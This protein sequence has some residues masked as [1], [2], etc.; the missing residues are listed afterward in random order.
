MSY[1]DGSGLYLAAFA[2]KEPGF[3]FNPQKIIEYLGQAIEYFSGGKIVFINIWGQFNDL[4]EYF[5][6]VDGREFY[7]SQQS[8]Y[9]DDM[10]DSIFDV[11]DFD[12][13]K[14]RSANRR[15]RALTRKD[16]QTNVSKCA[17]FNHEH[18]YIIERWMKAHEIS[19]VHKEF[20]YA[21]RSYIKR[22]TFTYARP[23]QG[24]LVGLSVMAVV[25]NERMVI[26]NSFPM[27]GDGL[28]AGDALFA[29][30]I[31]FA[32][33]KSVRWI[34]RGYSATDS[35]LKTKESWGSMARSRPYREAFY[36]INSEVTEMIKEDRFLWR[37]RLS[38]G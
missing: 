24:V 28:R 4:P 6:S 38:T 3:I 34:H 17:L 30:A 8:D 22:R 13:R 37:L 12:S 9:Y 2:L 27:R 1:C 33:K 21:L 31:S 23:D 18:L 36:V 32:R 11:S 15:I 5:T 19:I 29:E 20:F 25:G 16:I 7:L 35:L 26:L 14:L 10:F